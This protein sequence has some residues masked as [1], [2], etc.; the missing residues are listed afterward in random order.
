MMAELALPCLRALVRHGLADTV[1][2]W[3]GARD[4]GSQALDATSVM[5]WLRSPTESKVMAPKS[6]ADL[7]SAGYTMA[8]SQVIC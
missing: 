8:F 5:S 1:G 4:I 3:G 7:L 6:L 2:T